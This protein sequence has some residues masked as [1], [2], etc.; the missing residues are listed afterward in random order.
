[1]KRA[2]AYATLIGELEKWRLTPPVELAA[3]VGAPPVRVQIHHD[4]ADFEVEIAVSWKDSR[5][6]CLRIIG[7]ANGFSSWKLERLQESIVVPYKVSPP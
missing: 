3:F 6:N 2:V 1:M 5:K 7:T 4:G